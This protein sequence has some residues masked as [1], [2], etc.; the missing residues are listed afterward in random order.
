MNV[1]GRVPLS[2]Q[3]FHLA[4]YFFGSVG[5]LDVLACVLEEIGSWEAGGA[6]HWA[7]YFFGF[8]VLWICVWNI[9]GNDEPSSIMPA[10]KQ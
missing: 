9:L 1:S 6:C 10:L 2:Q 8:V 5:F 3:L 4:K 7:S